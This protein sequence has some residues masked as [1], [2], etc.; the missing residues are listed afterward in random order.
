M[1]KLELIRFL[2]EALLV[3]E[4]DVGF[5]IGA[6][7]ESVLCAPIDNDSKNEMVTRLKTL[8]SE[9]Q[10]HSRAISQLIRHEVS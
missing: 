2:N 6:L 1:D 4:V 5:K 10:Y 3:E 9:S 8:M 7:I